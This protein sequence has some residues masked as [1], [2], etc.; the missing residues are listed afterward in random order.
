MGIDELK[1]LISARLS[2]EEI[3]DILGWGIYDLVDVLEEYIV[4]CQDE[5]EDAVE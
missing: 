3:M 4:E 2:L 5:F 1:E